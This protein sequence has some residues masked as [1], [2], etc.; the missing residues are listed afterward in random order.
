M[1]IQD[2]VQRMEEMGFEEVTAR[3]NAEH[4]ST[5]A[6]VFFHPTEG[7]QGL[8][9]SCTEEQGLFAILD[10]LERQ[11]ALGRFESRS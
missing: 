1:G 10:F 11:L 5:L 3:Y 4:Q 8:R 7:P 2:A 9:C 6:Y